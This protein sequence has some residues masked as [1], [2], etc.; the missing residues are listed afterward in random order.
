MKKILLVGSGAREHVLAETILRSPQEPQLY[1]FAKT[2]NPGIMHMAQGYHLG[3]LMSNEEV[4]A[5]ALEIRPDFVIIGPE[6]PIG[7][8]LA[9]ALLAVG[10][11]AVA[12]FQKV[13]Q[14]EASKSFTRD[15]LAKYKIPGNPRYGV[16]CDIDEAENFARELEKDGLGFVIKADGLTGGKGVKVQGD[17]FETIADG[18]DFARE[19][20]AKSGRVV[21]EEKLVGQ[22]FS[23]MSFADGVHTVDMPIV[24]DHKRAF[25][26]DK[27]P[28]TGGM[29]TYSDSD[30][31][32]PF[33]SVEDA[34]EAR[35]ITQMVQEALHKE[36]GEF[37]RGIMYG[38]F[39]AV[40]DG[41]RL[42][43]YNMRFG[44]PEAMNTLPLLQTD[45][46]ELCSAMIDRSL[47]QI[48]VSFEP[49]ATVCK[50]IV[51]NGYPNNALKGE[52]VTLPS[53]VPAG[54]RLYYGSVDER[55]SGELELCGSRAI[56]VVGV[57]DT[58]AQAEQL[59][60]SAVSQIKGPVFYRE[61]IGT[62]K[63]IDTKI[64]M[65]HSLRK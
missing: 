15:L 11:D 63:L 20:I 7:N 37:Y 60:E 55:E 10:I 14:L 42:I 27:G 40:K 34:D 5:Y 35:V 50:Y 33:L 30:H 21:F 23:L 64:D 24:Q 45:F 8:G 1:V 22:E 47:D 56:A 2:N 41:V 52:V 44:D 28:N 39:I 31:L 38:G 6:D 51:P 43:E 26:G 61:D 12:P 16:F 13:A 32:L 4:I 9:D 36:T 62:K 58:I 65:M 48:L 54:V 29:G 19:C 59:A 18:M 49:K 46:L 3:N 25:A 57:G 53:E 17:H